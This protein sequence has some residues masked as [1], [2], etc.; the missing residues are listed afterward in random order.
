MA[1]CLERGPRDSLLG[2]WKRR[3]REGEAV[4]FVEVKVKERAE[5][6]K[7]VPLMAQLRE[8][9]LTWKK[10]LPPRHPMAKRL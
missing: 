2:D 5:Q 9:L 1:F 4:K 6:P 7:P 8:Q 10:Q 3:L